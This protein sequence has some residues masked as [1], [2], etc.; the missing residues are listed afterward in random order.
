MGASKVRMAGLARWREAGRDFDLE[1]WQRQ[2]AEA[3]FAAMWQ[4]VKEAS[5]I[6]GG[7]GRQP[8]LQTSVESLQRR[9][10]PGR[11]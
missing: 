1:F 8:R 10:G 2:G 5:A 9:G 3:R 4:M 6:R 11:A 7:D